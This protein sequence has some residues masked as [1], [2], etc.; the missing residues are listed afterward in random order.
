MRKSSF[1]LV[2]IL[3]A[4]FHSFGQSE[5]A[6]RLLDSAKIHLV[7]QAYTRAAN[8]LDRI[9][10][11]DPC[12]A[13]AVYLQL[14]IEQTRILDYESYTIDADYFLEQA[15]TS[16]GKLSG[17][18]PNQHGRDSLLCLF[19]IGNIQGGISVIQ[20]KVGNW[21]TAVKSGA[22]SIGA[23][24]RVI[25]AMPEYYPAYLGLGIFNYYISQNLKWLPFFTD[26]RKEGLEQIRIATGAEAPY[27]YSAK[28]SLCWVLLERNEYHTA[29]SI[30]SLVLAELPANTIFIRLKAR[31][32][33]WQ[34][35]YPEA[36]A[37]AK[38]LVVLSEKRIPVNWSDLLSGY[39]ILVGGSDAAGKK[40]ECLA[41]CR[42][43]LARP[44]PDPY[45]KISYVK[46]HLRYITDV[47]KK[48][49]N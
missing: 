25:R 26:R 23:F 14:A 29:D 5:N 48:Y 3:A 32:A 1:V 21:P 9:L 35:D 30:A 18:L 8:C 31:I 42:K 24:K 19:Y 12:N 28:N 49:A 33:Y 4:C 11:V 44:V 45:T 16:I 17:L 47:Q 20:A 7:N 13:E 46:K 39:Q 36:M 10:R 43:A 40:S 27:S 15:N 6:N 34:H 22:S 38:K 2:V 37:W 41:Y